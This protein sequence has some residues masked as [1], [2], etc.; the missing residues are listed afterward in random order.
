MKDWEV[1]R[2]E[3]ESDEKSLSFC[4][5]YQRGEKKS[6]WVKV[7][8]SYVSGFC[9]LPP[10]SRV[11]NLFGWNERHSSVTFFYLIDA[12]FLF[13]LNLDPLRQRS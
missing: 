7:F 4:F 3:D 1:R 6:R 9:T 8:S 2:L 12:F 5:Q 13:D 11:L 10:P